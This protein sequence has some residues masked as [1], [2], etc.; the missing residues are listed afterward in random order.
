[1]NENCRKGIILAGGKGTRLRPIT[2]GVCKQ[3]LP[4]YNKP[5]IY[6][7]LSTLMI[8]D[9]RE[10]LIITNQQDINNFKALYWAMGKSWYIYKL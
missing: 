7:P 2:F 8:S 1:M 4:L 6:Y 5:S 9:I 3:L 10:F